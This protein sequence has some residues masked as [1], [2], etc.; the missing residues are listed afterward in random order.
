MET[1][2]KGFSPTCADT[3]FQR[4]YAPERGRKQV[5]VSVGS[6]RPYVFHT[7]LLRIMHITKTYIMRIYCVLRVPLRKE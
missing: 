4:W 7:F 6:L 3:G 5:D 1:E 2:A